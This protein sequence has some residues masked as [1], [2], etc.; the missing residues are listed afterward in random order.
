[1]RRTAAR[2]AAGPGRTD[3]VTAGREGARTKETELRRVLVNGS[4]LLGAYVLPRALTFSAGLFAARLLGPEQFGA[5]GTAAAFAMILSILASLGMQPLLVREL[6]R[7]PQRASTILAAAQRIKLASAAIMIVTTFVV[8]RYLMDYPQAIVQ[9]AVLLAI[10]HA[11]A[12]L[13][14]NLGAWFQA[15]ERMHIWLEASIWFGIVSGLLGIAL[16]FWTRSVPHFAAAFAVGQLAALLWLRRRLPAHV[17]A[18]SAPTWQDVRPLL[19]ATAPFAAGFLALTIF[20]KFDVLLLQR[21][22]D[23]ADVGIYVA[24]YKLV[25]VAHALAVVASVAVYP[26]LARTTSGAARGQASRRTL[27]LFLLL[28]VAGSGTLWLIREPLTLLLFGPAYADTAATLGLLAPAL[29]ALVIN[30]LAGYL[31]SAADRMAP[32]ALA[33]LMGCTLKLVLALWWIPQYG[34]QGMALAKLTA[35]VL[36]AVALVAVLSRASAAVPGRRTLVLALAGS[37]VAAIISALP[38]APVLAAVLYLAIIVVLYGAGQALTQ[39]E[40]R[41]LGSA[42]RTRGPQAGYGSGGAGA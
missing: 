2:E 25:D 19:R 37:A 24:G 6:A 17:H 26:R 28:G 38:A 41:T 1:M 34:A 36:L 33:Y 35:E 22:G 31:L 13:G 39:A 10:G 40:W 42:L 14:E 4:A 16:V 27:E 12:A 30:I 23:A 11:F 3:S 20:Y 32:L 29:I 21:L 9:A 5:Y 8:A 18:G 15:D 7:T